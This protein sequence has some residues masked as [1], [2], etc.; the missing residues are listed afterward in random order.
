MDINKIKKLIQFDTAGWIA[1]SGLLICVLSGILLAIPYDFTHSFESVTGILLFNPSATLVRNLHYWSAQVFL[2]F[3]IFH[4][5]DHLNKS[6]ETNIRNSR[7]WLVLCLVLATLG[8]EMISGFIL[9]GDAGGIQARR[10]IASLLRNIPLAGNML[11]SALT[12]SEENWQ[13]IYIQHVATGTIILFIGVYEHVKRIWPKPRSF[14]LI[15][16]LLLLISLLFRA[17]LGLIESSQI[18]GPWFFIGIQEMLHLSS[19]PSYVISLIGIVFFVFYLIPRMSQRILRIIKWFLFVGGILYLSITFCALL[20]RG[21]NWQWQ[22]WNDFRKSEEKLVIFDPVNL[23]QTHSTVFTTENQKME[24]CLVCHGAMTGLTESHKPAII[25]CFACHKGDPFS[26]DKF[27]AHRSLIKI[28][29]NFSNVRQT[30]GTQNC[31]PDIAGRMENSLMTTQSGI[32]GVDKFV[33]GETLSLNDTFQAKNLGQSMADSHLRNLCAGCHLGNDKLMTG[34]SAWLERGGGCGAC[35]L[36]Y[37]DQAL[38]SM[39]RMQSNLPASGIEVHPSIDIQVSNDRCKSCHS[40]SGRISLNYEGWNETTLK[41]SEVTDS[42]HQ[43]VLPDERVVEYVQSDIH[44][45]KGMA[46]IDC[47]G[48]YEIMGDGKHQVHKEDGVKVQCMDCHLAGNSKSVLVARLSDR[49]SQMVAWLR[50]IDPKNSLVVTAKGEYPLMNTRVDSSER[51][52]L[53]GK[54]TGKNHLSKPPSPIC[55]KGKGHNRLSCE[56]CHTSWVPQCIGCHNTFEKDTKGYDLLTHKSVIGTWVEYA[57][58]GFARAPVLGVSDKI[59]GKIVTAMPGMVMTTDREPFGR[60]GGTKFHRLYAPASGHTTV[61]EG[62]S[63]KSCHN[64]PLAIGYGDGTLTYS[65]IGSA[66]KWV[67]EPKFA[68]NEHDS[69]PED[70]WVGFLKEGRIPY[71]TR[72]WLRPFTVKEQQHILEI[73]SC[74]TCHDGKSMVMDMALEDYSKICLKRKRQCIMPNW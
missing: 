58:R 5:Y 42:V 22:G 71:A 57:G 45:Q 10:I 1:I 26:L 73:G 25:G 24:G 6:T 60:G 38:K 20:F 72:N 27:S 4:I 21:E 51:I 39:K 23:F 56:S 54:L 61:R 16:V 29:G 31:H 46:C 63:C 67:F 40:R 43:K 53:T 9:K 36:H 62:R 14:A 66:G 7:T 44:H 64:N 74:L 2:I 28:P 55:T 37:N 70:A 65:I 15:F 34:N 50:K 47:H 41:A 59:P 11:S 19:H 35:H 30:C 3:T 13:I 32:I 8:Y 48:S 12:G 17:P 52:W 33:F 69:L 49:E 68:M 18:K